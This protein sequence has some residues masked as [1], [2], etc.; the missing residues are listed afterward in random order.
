M[1]SLTGVAL[2][3]MVTPTLTGGYEKWIVLLGYVL[4]LAGLIVIISGIRKSKSEGGK[5]TDK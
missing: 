3:K 4:S 5:V 2:V 1:I